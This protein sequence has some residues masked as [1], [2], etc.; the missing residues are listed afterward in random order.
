MK[1][2]YGKRILIFGPSGKMGCAIRSVFT[3][4]ELINVYR[5]DCD[6]C[7]FH[8]VAAKISELVPDMVVN[9]VVYGGLDACEE[10]P[11]EALHVNTLFPQ[12]LAELSNKYNFILIHFSTDAVFNG[13]T[14][15]YHLESSPVNPVNIY[16]ITKFG[17]D[18][19]IRAIAQKY[20]IARLSIQ[21]GPSDKNTQFLEK[22]LQKIRDGHRNLLISND[23]VASPSFSADCVNELK[24]IIE[25][26]R[27]YGLYHIA[28]A[29]MASLYELMQEIIK[30]LKI[31]VSI[32]PVPHTTFNTKAIKNSFTPIQSEKLF[33]LRPWQE[34]LAAYCRQLII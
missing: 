14:A 21:F 4:C 3:E 27:P 10:R 9:A 8:Q 19:Y 5:A 26:E 33:P 28:N 16:G 20:Y 15:D 23:I 7:D 29:G 25:D 1:R 24:S 13:T 32:T 18:S 11:R 22:M 17:A 6:I 12:Y 2:L 31:D 34:A 30:I